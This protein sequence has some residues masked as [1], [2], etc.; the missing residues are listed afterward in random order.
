MDA[1]RTTRRLAIA[2]ALALLAPLLVL[3]SAQPAAAVDTLIPTTTADDGT[4]NSLRGAVSLASS[5]GVEAIIEL[6]GGA[7][8]VID[9]DCQDGD[10][11]DN[12]GGDLDWDGAERLTIRSTSSELATIEV[13][14]AGERVFDHLGNDTVRFERIRITGGNTADGALGDQGGDRNG[15]NAEHG[16][17]IRA[18]GPVDLRFSVVEGNST[19]RGGNGAPTLVGFGNGGAGGAAGAG[20]G[21]YGDRVVLR[22]TTVTDNHTGDGGRGGNGTGSFAGG[23]GG[24]GG[25]GGGVWALDLVLDRATIEANTAGDGGAGGSG[26]PTNGNGGDGGLGGRMAGAYGGNELAMWRTTVAANAAGAGGAGGSGGGASGDGG[27]GGHGGRWAGI[28]ASTAD[29]RDSTITANTGGASGA[30]GSGSPNGAAGGL[31]SG[32][33][34]SIFTSGSISFTTVVGNASGAASNIESNPVVTIVASVVGE[35]GGTGANCSNFLVSQGWNVSDSGSCGVLTATDLVTPTLG[36]GPL[37]DN[38]GPTETMMP[39]PDSPIAGFIPAADCD[40][41]P[42]SLSSDQR[43]F[44]RPAGDCEAGAVELPVPEASRFVPLPPQRVF[45]TRDGAAPSGY[46]GAGQTINVDF[47]GVVGVPASGVSAVAFNLTIDAAGGAGFVTAFPGLTAQPLASNL[48][49][50]RAG[51]IVPN[52]VIVPVGSDGTVSFY[53]Q[54]GGHLLADIAGYFEEVPFARA[55]RIVTQ[56]PS[57]LFD[58]RDAGPA[59]FVPAGGQIAVPV[60]GEAGVPEDGVAAVVVNLTGTE[61]AAAGFVTGWSG[62]GPMPTASIL[63]LSGPGHTAPNLAILPVGA[64]GAIRFFSQ[65]GAHLLGD[66]TGWITDDTAVASTN[67]LMVPVQPARV[68]DTREPGPPAGFVGPAGEIVAPHTGVAGVPEG[69]G[70]VVLNVT[71]TEAGGAGYITTWPEGQAMPLASTLN[72]TEVG[73]TRANAAILPVGN[74]GDIRYFTQTGAHLLADAF[75]YLLQQPPVLIAIPS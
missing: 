1:T 55:G 29:V 7:T 53:T 5:G 13:Q 27:D 3:V 45:D 21:I 25:D 63:N 71:G 26:G 22:N 35:P 8:Y 38:G 15:G 40:A 4:G 58:T 66:V 44:P 33:G 41:V 17:G 34:L 14:C 46:V 57:R 73:E 23:P 47:T 49:T 12:H 32:A 59:G 69:A 43:V 20:A 19:G 16:G 9:K 28:R 39:E 52:L 64:D 18:V 68:F 51:Q 56:T 36:L 50:V 31:S 72:L 11:D 2:M 6:E 75:G 42:T 37:A 24:P 60:L 67:G 74:D 70:G 54:S 48:N 10:L 30:G 62:D 65:S 61:A